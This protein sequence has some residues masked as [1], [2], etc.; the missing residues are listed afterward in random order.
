MSLNDTKRVFESYKPIFKNSERR[1]FSR[2]FVSLTGRYMLE[3]RMEHPCR[4]VDISPGGLQLLGSAKPSIGEKVVVYID[5]LGRFAGSAVRIH[6]DGFAMTVIASAKKRE[7][8]AEQLTWYANRA[9]LDLPDAR[10][11]ERFKPFHKLAVLRLFEGGEQIVKIRD[12]SASGVSL[13]G[14]GSPAIGEEVSIGSAHA[15]VVRHVENGF[16]AEFLTPFAA[17]EID[18]STRL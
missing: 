10:R 8:L 4:T 14:T 5:A 18:E 2:V 3:S 17:G 12:L 6:S 9:T 1:R 16:A 11:H 7:L 13:E 15:K